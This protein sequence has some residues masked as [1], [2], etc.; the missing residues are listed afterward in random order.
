MKTALHTLLGVLTL[1]LNLHPSPASSA[2]SLA[3]GFSKP[4]LEARPWVYWFWLNGNITSNGITAD[5]EAM[6][7]VGIGGVL[8]MEVDQGA[9]VGPVDFVGK[10]WRGLFQ[11]V[12]AEARRLGLKVNM[13]ND[14][15]W[16]GSGGPWIRPEESMQKV[17]WSETKV[18]GPSH[19]DGKLDQP[20]AVAG[21]YRDIAVLA[22]PS[23]G[24]SFRID[25][26]AARADYNV[27]DAGAIEEKPLPQRV[28]IP[29]QR[30]INLSTKMAPDGHLSW[31][32][33]AGHWTIL[34]FGHTS[35]G[36]D[37]HPA[38]KTG[39]G[40]ECDKLSK[41]GIDANFAGMMAK[42]VKDNG[43]K[44]GMAS[45]GL[46]AT[47]IDS[48]ENGAQNWTANMRWEFQKRCGYDLLPFLP[49]FTGRVVE[50]LEVSERFLWDLRQ[51]VSELVIE[52]YAGEMHR[53]A[54]AHGLR[55]TCEAYGGP[56][57]SIPY[58]GQADE[59]MGE[60][61]SPSGAIETCR[62]MACAGHLY[63]KRII[64]AESFTA[65][66]GERWRSYPGSLKALGDRAFCEGINRFVFHRYALQPWSREYRPG[67]TMGPW[68]QHYERTET[69][70]NETR[71]WHRYL[72]R[73]QYLLRQGQFVADICYLQPEEAPQGFTMHSPDGYDWDECDADV[74]LNLMSVKD[75]RIV[76]P[77][78]MSYRVLV[79]PQT[80]RMTPQLLSKVK[81]LAMAGAT[82]LGTPPLASP[83]LSDYPQCDD[84]VNR[85][86]S[87]IWGDCDGKSVLQRQLGKGRIVWGH[88]PARFLRSSGVEPDFESGQPLHYIHRATE[89]DDIY[90][91]ASSSKRPV[92]TSATFRVSGKVPHLWWPETGRMERAPI[93]QEAKG[94]TSVSLSL[95]PSGSVFVVFRAE[96]GAPAPIVRVTRNGRT[97]FS[98]APEI[99]SSFFGGAMTPA[100]LPPVRIEIKTAR[101]GVLD[102]PARTRNVRTKLQRM[103]DAGETEFQV[104]RLAQ[105]DDPAYMVVK[106]LEV[107][108]TRN[109]KQ[110][111]LSATD[112]DT[113]D[114]EGP[115]YLAPPIA[116]VR[117]DSRGRVRLIAFQSGHYEFQTAAGEHRDFA[118]GP[119][120]S[121]EITGPWDVRFAPGWGA[122]DDI[123]LDHLVSWTDC[124]EPGVKYFSGT[125]TYTRT[126]TIP[127]EM[128][129]R[130]KRL[131]L[132]L[133]QVDVIARVS[134]NGQDL[135]LLWKPPFRL[136]ITRAAVAGD[137]RLE[138]KVT[139]LWPNRMIGDQQLP[140]DSQRNPN[141]TLKRWPQWVLEDKP[142]PTGRFTFTTWR[143]WKKSSPLLDSGLL[144]PVRII[145]AEQRRLPSP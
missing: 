86:A 62:G 96:T 92:T 38:P 32:V 137:N 56:C 141:G 118:V 134:L 95:G 71:P 63:G 2:D 114:L 19:F 103:V 48:W 69:W 8:I 143:L 130:G 23:V 28:V 12:V 13:N 37:N 128:K 101:Y 9:P 142:S 84:E 70:W 110:F 80:P 91:V 108:Y 124:A 33:P 77:D 116:A 61:W 5:L 89:E 1:L 41:R 106:T 42:L 93:Y 60:F 46:V 90:F 47:H 57:D 4:P 83:S 99:H 121:E 129:G 26:L 17:V 43:I 104:A 40:L 67:M 117:T 7:R 73:C 126:L 132:D 24:S 105:G 50:S 39:L 22:V 44:P 144:G 36:V 76:L 97:L 31:D 145:A 94:H 65:G 21:Y 122:P 74:V 18:S 139:N 82:V 20:K 136:D 115:A 113:V 72:A 52:N 75:G 35:T 120:R 54:H 51:T 81:T 45:P 55:F 30:I 125:A 64:G 111:S 88:D 107:T 133:G 79:L 34:R 87:E 53:L 127:P 11:H 138:V 66:D 78:G 85:L 29:W 102:D 131:F 59:P 6:Q 49:V 10:K 135:G 68:G 119:I 16:D 140:E 112:P 109:G 14:A 98:T 27:G 100:S 58:G 3:K 25:K 15:G 123:T